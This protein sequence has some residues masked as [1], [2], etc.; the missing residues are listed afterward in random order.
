[1]RCIVMEHGFEI[2][3]DDDTTKVYP[4]GWTGQLPP[5]EAAAL[6]AAGAARYD[7]DREATLVEAGVLEITADEPLLGGLSA[8]DVS[9]LAGGDYGL[10]IG[11]AGAVL[12]SLESL[13]TSEAL[14]LDVRLLIPVW[15]AK[16]EDHFAP[17]D[18][19]EPVEETSPFASGG[20]V[21]PRE[22]FPLVGERA[23]TEEAPGEAS[24]VKDIESMTPVEFMAD[25]GARAGLVGMLEAAGIAAPGEKAL[26]EEDHTDAMTPPARG[27]LAEEV[28]PAV[29]GEA[30]EDAAP[31]QGMLAEE[32]A[33]RLEEGQSEAL[34]D[35]AAEE[36]PK[37]RSSKS[38]ARA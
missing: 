7:E 6:V 33:T 3:N 27:A 8:E 13:M 36:A 11:A 9:K 26:A 25:A 28:A 35:V 37:S 38:R 23:P 17:L 18:E 30:T 32:M 12:V 2:P 22:D 21:A 20:L 34:T 14:G 31:A 5:A 1:M 29:D 15:P 10:V 24:P 4:A 19:A 16:A